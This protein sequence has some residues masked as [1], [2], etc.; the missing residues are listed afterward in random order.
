MRL[1]GLHI[2]HGFSPEARVFAGLLR[3]RG[4]DY[5]ALVLHHA[6]PVDAAPAAAGSTGAT[7]ADAADRFA[8]EA[9]V[10]VFRFDGGYRPWSARR[11]LAEKVRGAAQFQV[12]LRRLLPVARAFAPDVVYS[13][14]QAADC[15]AATF[16]ARRLARPQIIHLHYHIGPWLKRPVLD[17]LRTCDHVVAISD[18][19]RACGLE[20]GIAPGRITTVRNALDAA[21]FSPPSPESRA[22]VRRELGLAP[23]A[24]LVGIV[25]RLDPGKGHEDTIDAFARV[26]A[27]HP[28]SHLVVVGDGTERAAYE[29]H[30]RRQTACADRIHFLGRRAD[31][32]RLLPGFDL[33]CHPSRAEPFGLAV[34]EAAASG[35]PILAYDEGGTP[36]IV[37]DGETGFLAPPGDV[38]ALADKMS[39]L[40]ERPDLRREM[41]DAGRR[42]A[43]DEF[44]PEDAAEQFARVLKRVARHPTGTPG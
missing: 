36:E 41:G 28:G 5:S 31:V 37:R 33:F 14:Q 32:P 9:N 34:L 35:L 10:E 16:L 13:N 30:A 6:Y 26:A 43:V 19:I 12:S 22:W 15:L 39:L 8:S 27:R 29:A 3:H 44:R 38:A 4:D 1:L 17:R 20:H 40:L 21:P 7:D 42:R 25:S 11:S 18:F 2:N 24:A 23:D